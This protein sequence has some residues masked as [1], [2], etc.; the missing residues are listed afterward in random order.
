MAAEGIG[1]VS[2]TKNT[3]RPFISEYKSS[4]TVFVS[5]TIAT[6]FWIISSILGSTVIATLALTSHL[7]PAAVYYYRYRPFG[8][9][10]EYT[11]TARKNGSV[12]WIRV[13]RTGAKQYYI[14]VNA[15]F[16]ACLAFLRHS[17]HSRFS[18]NLRQRFR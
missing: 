11:P 15:R 16:T 4:Q 6:V 3:F 9:Q 1:F 17:L 10:I 12:S 8:I 14:A 7:V 18:S 13:L 5:T 2:Y